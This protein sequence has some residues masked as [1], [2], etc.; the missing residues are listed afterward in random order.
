ADGDSFDD[1][2]SDYGTRTW[3]F[4]ENQ[5]GPATPWAYLSPVDFVTGVEEANQSVPLEFKIIGNYPNP[6]NPSTK[7]RYSLPSSGDITI[8]IYNILGQR[9]FS[10]NLLNLSKGYHDFEFNANT[11]ASGVYF[12]Q[13]IYRNGIT[14]Q[15]TNSNTGKMLL[16]K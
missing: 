5:G 2:L 14:G 6:F 8:N 13:I 1:A 15:I 16:L 10:K 11:F 4:R 12:Y 3:W 9:V 7:I